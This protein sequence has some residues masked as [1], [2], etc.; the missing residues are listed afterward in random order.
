MQCKPKKIWIIFLHI[1]TETKAWISKNTKLSLTT[2]SIKIS[3]FLSSYW[4]YMGIHFLPFHRA[5]FIISLFFPSHWHSHIW[6][7]ILLKITRSLICLSLYFRLYAVF[8]QQ[9]NGMHSLLHTSLPE[10]FQKYLRF[11]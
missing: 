2:P 1:L 5:A 11:Y 10:H 7:F 9:S 6:T 3:C 4:P 8:A